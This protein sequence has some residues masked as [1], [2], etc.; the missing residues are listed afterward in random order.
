MEAQSWVPPHFCEVI[1]W[2]T[3]RQQAPEARQLTTSLRVS[4]QDGS[5]RFT[6]GERLQIALTTP[7]RK[8]SYLYVL[9]HASNGDVVPLLPNDRVPEHRFTPGTAVSLGQPHGPQYL[10]LTCPCGL[11]LVTVFACPTALTEHPAGT[12]NG[13]AVWRRLRPELE[14][15]ACIAGAYRVLAVRDRTGTN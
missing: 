14:Q 7:E 9:Y 10:E 6:P 12:A 3:A 15:A 11:E 8:L 13:H 2:I 4:T 5:L 1:A